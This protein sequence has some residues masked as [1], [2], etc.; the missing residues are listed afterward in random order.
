MINKRL[1]IRNLL[2]FHG[3]NSFY[4]KKL[5]LDLKTKQGKAKLLKHV[6]ALSNANPENNSYIVVGVEDESN[7]IVGV[8]FY[9]D[10]KIQNLINSYLEN[11]PIILFENISFPTLKKH[12]V[13]GL[14]TIKP[15]LKVTY[16]KKF[17]WKYPFKTQFIRQGSIS[18]PVVKIPEIKSNKEIVEAIEN[19]A[20]NNLKL[21]LEST[22]DF[23]KRHKNQEVNHHVFNNQFVICWSGKKHHF[24]GQDYY[25]RVDISMINEE[26]TL[27]YSS[28]DFVQ[29]KYNSSS[30]IITEFIPLHLDKTKLFPLEKTVISFSNNT[31]HLVQELLFKIPTLEKKIIHHLFIANNVISNK[32][33]NKEKLTSL[34][35]KELEK[36]PFNLLLCV[37]NGYSQAN[38]S[39]KLLKKPLK[40]NKESRA[41]LNYKEV[42]RIFR[43]LK[44]N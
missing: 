31:Y 32:L 40:E 6:C 24:E 18:L 10:S 36:L 37:L 11:P 27:F 34:E 8:P 35:I 29:I 9:D 12:K 28:L 2:A 43:K 30:F 21:T 25:S 39:F 33:M 38:I 4:D 1:L 41:Y 15:K 22:F 17:I 23:I 16:F 14:I 26:V 42:E 7:K 3:E 20:K 13:I 19:N 44:Y 5:K